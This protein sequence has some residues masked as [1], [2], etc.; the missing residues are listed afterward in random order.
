MYNNS[1]NV[2]NTNNNKSGFYTTSSDSDNDNFILNYDNSI[3]MNIINNIKAGNIHSNQ[4]D[5]K[6]VKFNKKSSDTF[7]FK[8]KY[9]IDS[10]LLIFKSKYS[11]HNT[12][13]IDYNIFNVEC[14]REIYVLFNELLKN[15]NMFKNKST[16][17]IKQPL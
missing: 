12:I 13:E 2:N 3:K 15:D 16:L 17:L 10:N 9:N 5:F 11:L 4:K 1:N 6:C 8:G 14:Q 7:K